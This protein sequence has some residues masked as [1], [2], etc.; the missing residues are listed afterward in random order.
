[1]D[2]HLH[3]YVRPQLPILL[4]HPCY[5]CSRKSLLL[6][7]HASLRQPQLRLLHYKE[8]IW[9]ARC[10]RTLE[11]ELDLQRCSQLDSQPSD[12]RHN[13]ELR[14]LQGR[15]QR[16]GADAVLAGKT[17]VGLDSHGIHV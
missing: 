4:K 17:K 6:D 11:M 5:L 16:L 2:N 15:L 8:K 13:Q 3:R 10:E 7:S 1:M 14:R 12:C 9:E